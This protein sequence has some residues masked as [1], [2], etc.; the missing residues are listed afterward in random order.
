MAADRG[1]L[2]AF[3]HK[4]FSLFTHGLI[5][6]YPWSLLSSGCET[7]LTEVIPNDPVVDA[8]KVPSSRDLFGHP[9]GLWVLVLTEGCVAFSLY[10]MQA[11]LVLYLA[12][13]LLQPGHVDHVLGMSALKSFLGAIYAPVGIQATAGAITGLFLALIYATPLLGGIV[14]DRFL[15]RT[16]TIFLG[17]I[18][19]TVGHV[20]MSFDW[21]FVIAIT[22]L[23]LGLGAAGGLRAQVGALYALDDPRRS[24]AYQIYSL[25][26][27]A[28][29]IAAPALCAYL[30]I[31]AWHWGF[32]AASLGMLTGLFVYMLGRRWL[33]EDGHSKA[34]TP[35]PSL[36]PAEKKTTVLL[37][38]LLPVLALSALPNSEIFDGYL[39]W[40]REHYQLTLLGHPFPVSSLVSLDGLVSTVCTISVLG[41]W[42][43]YNRR[44][45]D[46]A[47]I[48]KV[49]IGAF[50]ASC[51]PLVLALASW[52]YPA[53]HQVSLLWGIAFHTINDIGFSM[54]YAI[55]MALYSRAAPASLN[56]ILVACFTLHLFLANLTIGKLSTLIGHVAD[57]PFWLIHS[58]ACLL[59]ACILLG[60]SFLW[61]D[62]LAPEK[63]AS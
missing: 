12:D 30:A 50:I 29:V 43:F 9:R 15:G 32:L 53:P 31:K 20:L 28:A 2:M 33:P 34:I 41:F 63:R 39:L 48:T 19:M 59:A 11:I 51:G 47:E 37:L 52:L 1:L 13:Y 3:C 38:A 61:R 45:P 6:L 42:K 5:G 14:A 4:F 7:V 8:V 36:T 56:T 54:S 60:C 16:R 10:G 22:T 24:E 25:G 49:A 62:L 46:P 17:A 26:V 35:R 44:R 27:Q 57:V 23:L 58:G 21:S 55:G 40:G 18:F